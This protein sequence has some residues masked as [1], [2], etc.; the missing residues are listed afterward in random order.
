MSNAKTYTLFAGVNGAGKSTFFKSLDI[1]F[2]TRI[3]IDEIVREKYAC[4]GGNKVYRKGS[5][6]P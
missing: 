3:N 1:D 2:G 6:I 4:T 5:A